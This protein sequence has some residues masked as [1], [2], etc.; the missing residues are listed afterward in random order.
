MNYSR[1]VK[2]FIN[3]NN[4]D[5][6]PVAKG[7][8]RIA[9]ELCPERT[10]SDK[11][12]HRMIAGKRVTRVVWFC[13]GD[14]VEFALWADKDGSFS[15]GDGWVDVPAWRAKKWGIL[16]DYLSLKTA[17]GIYSKREQNELSQPHQAGCKC[18]GSFCAVLY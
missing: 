4:S 14:G 6:A 3:N 8:V 1:I 10:I 15:F 17:D 7:H 9:A 11:R 18:A 12:N 13:I 5:F 16:G 2:P